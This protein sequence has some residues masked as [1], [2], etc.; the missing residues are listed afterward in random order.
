MIA[1]DTAGLRHGSDVIENEGIRRARERAETSD[2]RLVLF[3]GTQLHDLDPETVK[4]AY[5]P[6][7]VTVITKSD[8]MESGWIPPAE[9]PD[10]IL[11]SSETGEGIEKLVEQ[12]RLNVEIRHGGSTAP[13]LTRVRHLVALQD[14]L[15]GLSGYQQAGE[16]ELAAEDLR[17]AVRALGKITG[18]VDVEDVLDIIFKEF[19]IGK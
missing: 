13:L 2:H 11:V 12:L 14:C 18:R 17:L 8:L 10:P 6:D 3:D 1:A 15:S 19:C 4:L 7:T 16:V 5:A 9:L